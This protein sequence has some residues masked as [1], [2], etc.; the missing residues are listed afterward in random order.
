MKLIEKTFSVED[1]NEDLGYYPIVLLSDTI[2]DALFE[3]IDERFIEKY[4]SLEEP[5]LDKSYFLE[6]PSKKK[7]VQKKRIDKEAIPAALFISLFVVLPILFGIHLFIQESIGGIGPLFVGLYM[8][9]HLSDH[10][11]SNTRKVFVEKAISKKVLKKEWKHYNQIKVEYHEKHNKQC[12]IYKR[13]LEKYN[14]TIIEYKDYAIKQYLRKIHSP[15]V[16]FTENTENVKRG[17]LEIKFL[18]YLVQEFGDQI[19]VDRY[20]ETKDNSYQPD[21][22][23]KSDLTGLCIDIEIDEPYAFI[24]KEPIHFDKIDEER[25]LSFIENNWCVVRFSEKQIAQSPKACV[26]FLRELIDI[27][28]LEQ[29]DFVDSIPFDK[30]WSYEMALVMADNNYRKTYNI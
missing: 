15:T 1:F 25:N 23:F 10:I 20:I 26:K 27:L 4:A 17:R 12:E 30:R 6:E 24:N 28:Y 8:I 22:I 2:K 7:P 29:Y 21:F 11:K 3:D 13:K 18:G 5:R 16:D 14:V 9:R 19:K